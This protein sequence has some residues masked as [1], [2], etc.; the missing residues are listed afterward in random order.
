[1]DGFSVTVGPTLGITQAT[2]EKSVSFSYD[3]FLGV[4][5]K[6]VLA[7][8]N[9]FGMGYRIA[10]QQQF[11]IKDHLFIGFRADFSND[12]YGDVNTFLGGG[13]SYKF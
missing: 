11:A 7:T 13:I 10:V 9:H 3:P 4:I 8:E 1:M 12:V 5:R 6:S 2:S